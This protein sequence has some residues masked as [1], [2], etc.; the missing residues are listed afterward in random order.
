MK[1]IYKYLIA[2]LVIAIG[3]T[4]F[5]NKVYIPKTT[6]K[7]L[8]ASIGNLDVKVFGIGTLD[9]KNIYNITAGVNAKI[10]SL[11]TDAGFWVKKGDLL[12]TLDPV[13][14]P[15]LVQES[16]ISVTKAYS[17][18]I[19]SEKELNSLQ[20]QKNLAKVTYTRYEKLRKNSF[21]SQSE[22]D[23]AK[24]DLEV[25]QAQME[26]TSAHIK[27]SKTEIKRAKKSVAALQEKLSR[28]KIY[29]PIDGYVISKD[30]EIA[31]ALGAT[32]SI[33]KIVSPH[34]VWIKAYVDERISGDIHVGD[35]AKIKLR[36]QA[37]KY[38]EAYVKRVAPQSDAVTQERE[39]DVA[40]KKL[41][42]PFYMNEQAE[43]TIK[44]SHLENVVKIAAEALIY[45]EGKSGVWVKQ[46]NR[47]HFQTVEILA[48]SNNKVALK[49]FNTNAT[50]LL[51]SE[52]NK[53]LVEGMK[54]H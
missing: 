53:A 39:V 27:S 14:L 38:Y 29:A 5:Y 19:A 24:A 46:A 7:T 37:N 43:V 40:F 44:V 36:S 31:Q 49:N 1:S 35:S 21:A 54:V 23:K 20:A 22:Y 42:L 52:H 50:I 13:D 30:A 17:D 3:A 45:I 41:P 26:V 25:V 32:Q 47:A 6:Y 18:M 48:I 8:H 4:V 11:H 12:A 34:D 2:L 33:F 10:L 28:Y 51:A 9:A 16:K 15:I